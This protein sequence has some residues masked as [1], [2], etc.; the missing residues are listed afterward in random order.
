MMLSVTC[1]VY[2]MTSSLQVVD[3]DCDREVA[4]AIMYFVDAGD[5]VCAPHQ[6]L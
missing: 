4:R 6:M 2:G 5:A 1:K 3:I